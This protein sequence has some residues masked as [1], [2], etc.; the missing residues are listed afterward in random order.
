MKKIGILTLHE[1]SNFGACLQAVATY[2][3]IE[4]LGGKCEFVNYVCDEI[5]RREILLGEKNEHSFFYRIRVFIKHRD[6]VKKQ[7]ICIIAVRF[8]GSRRN[9]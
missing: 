2:K 6:I 7:I 8:D 1:S 4:Q 9:L 5:A 3:V